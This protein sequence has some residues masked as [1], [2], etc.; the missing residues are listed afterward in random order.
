MLVS[1]LN[2]IIDIYNGLFTSTSVLDTFTTYDKIFS[3]L[4]GD[5]RFTNIV[6]VI[7]TVGV[8]IMILYFLIDMADK[9]S[10]KNFN[11]EYF[12]KAFI[13]LAV[14]Y[15]LITNS[16]TI[17]QYMV[18]A[19]SALAKELNASESAASFFADTDKVSMLKKGLKKVGLIDSVGYMVKIIISWL[20]VTIANISVMFIA[21]SRIVEL[22]VRAMFAP[23]GVADLFGDGN[24]AAGIRYLKKILALALQFALVVII[25]DCVALLIQWKVGPDAVNAIESLKTATGSSFSKKET[26]AFLDAITGS[27]KFGATWLTC[28]ALTITKIGLLFKSMGI[29]ND[30]AGV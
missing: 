30:V 2:W 11:Y 13:K 9:A 27:G 12:I 6:A 1:V 14:A 4:M 8:S 20:I 15:M 23:V 28:M 7:T 26:M 3:K 21:I 24:H 10:S 5:S 19:G 16:M 17:I 18:E 25:T 22:S 29:A